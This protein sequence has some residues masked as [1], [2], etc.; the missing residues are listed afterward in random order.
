MRFKVGT[1]NN[2]NAIVVIGSHDSQTPFQKKKKKKK[3]NR[4]TNMSLYYQLVFAVLVF[5]VKSP[6]I[7]SNST[8]RVNTS[9]TMVDDSV[10]CPSW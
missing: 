3:K 1:P 4:L 7:S 9:Q 6:S 8:T 2:T 10:Y 5:E